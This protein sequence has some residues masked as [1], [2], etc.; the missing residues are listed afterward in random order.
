VRFRIVA[1]AQGSYNS[2]WAA[3]EAIAAKL[4]IGRVETPQA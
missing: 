3:I 1:E 4:D 2:R